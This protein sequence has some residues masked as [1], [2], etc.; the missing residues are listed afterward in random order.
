VAKS[1]K[2]FPQ[3]NDGARFLESKGEYKWTWPTGE[4][5]LFRVIRTESDYD[6]YHGHEYPFIGW[7]ELTKYP[8]SALYDR[9]MSVNRTS[10]LPAEHRPVDIK[11]GTLS[12]PLPE[13]PLVV[14]STSNP[15]GVGHNWVK[16]RFIDVAPP[17]R[18]VKRVTNVF[19]PRT[20]ARTDVV[21][22]QVRIFG[23]Y[24]ENKYLSP[25]YIAE[26]ENIRD[27][28][29]RKAWLYGDWNIIAGGALD[30]VWGE[31]VVV[32]RFQVPKGWHVD[33][34]FDWGSTGPFSYGVWAESNGED[35]ILPDGTTWCPPRGTL[36]RIYEWYGCDPTR[37]NVGLKLSARSV[38][39]GIREREA[40][41]SEQGWIRG[42]V[43]PGPAD[44]AIGNINEIDEESI[45]KKM[46]DCGVTW[47]ASDKS[48]GSRR[49][50]L[51]LIRE[52]LE[53]SKNG[54]H[55]GLF[56]MDNCRDAIAQLPVMPR[57]EK[58]P[59]D[60]DSDAEDH[61]YDEVRYRVLAGSNRVATSI[62]VSFPM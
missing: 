25:E 44:N 17:G 7:N 13:I 36:V 43:W 51:E 9:M 56:F 42:M 11:T 33:R 32:P 53:A 6:N 28:N 19:N 30:D 14:F 59:D 55:P 62:S 10:F 34:S 24:K 39:E 57:D 47:T 35:A 5:L 18:V 41:L 49:N 61:I 15:Y 22:T 31:H 8:T 1:K 29:M 4:E 27:S 37:D 40:I 50:G 16:K 54:E 20:Q 23:S 3:W 60:V 48:S 2:W 21:K 12:D 26:L 45:Q 52:R 38:A 58:D 46:A